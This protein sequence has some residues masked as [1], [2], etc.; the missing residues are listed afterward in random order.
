MRAEVRGAAGGR[1]RKSEPQSVT[2][3]RHHRLDAA[4]LAEEVNVQAVGIVEAM[5]DRGVH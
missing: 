3:W 2:G 5:G 1:D 4:L